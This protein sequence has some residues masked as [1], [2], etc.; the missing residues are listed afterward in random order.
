MT[1][2]DVTP[3]LNV[4]TLGVRDFQVSAAFYTALGFVR[5]FRATGDEIAFFEA[6]GAVLAL[7]RWDALAADARLPAAPEP[8]AFRGMTLAWNCNMSAEVDV[9][10]A[11]AL[12]AGATPLRQPGATDYGGYCGY[13]ADPNGHVW[14]VVQAPGLSVTED[15]RLVLPD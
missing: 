2:P 11:R 10:F 5:K 8:G 7:F 15:G 1:T 3:R 12:A 6:G 14:E 4:V 9:A 13:F